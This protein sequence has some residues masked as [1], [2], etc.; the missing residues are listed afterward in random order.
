MFA[1][2]LAL[3]ERVMPALYSLLSTIVLMVLTRDMLR[4][5]YLQPWFSRSELNVQASYSP[6]LVFLLFFIGG[7]VLIGWMLKITFQDTDDQEVQS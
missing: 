3:K 7:I 5:L 1:T 6:L 2:L 4:T